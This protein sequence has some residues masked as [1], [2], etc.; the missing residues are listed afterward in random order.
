MK[1]LSLLNIEVCRDTMHA[2]QYH[3]ARKM[4]RSY[5]RSLLCL[6]CGTIKT[7]LLDSKGHILKTN[8][9]YPAGYVRAKGSGRFTAEDRAQF[10]LSHL[11]ELTR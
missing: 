5:E 6:N 10:R 8:Y 9:R 2:W 1:K 3:T 7:Q 11:K 4:G